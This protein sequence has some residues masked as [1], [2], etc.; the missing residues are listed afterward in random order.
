MRTI[1]IFSKCQLPYNIACLDITSLNN[2]DE[3][4]NFC[5]IGLWTQIS[6]WLCRLPTLEITHKESLTSGNNKYSR[7]QII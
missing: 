6:V 7:Y 3:K 1:Y 4:S 2:Q 5:A